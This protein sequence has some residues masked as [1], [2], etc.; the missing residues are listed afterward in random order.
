MSAAETPRGR[1]ILFAM[2]S[3]LVNGWAARD[4]GLSPRIRSV[5]ARTIWLNRVEKKGDREQTA[6][7]S[8]RIRLDVDLVAKSNVR[9]YFRVNPM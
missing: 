5:P 1:L 6:C 7:K 8:N 9:F 4:A 2:S 3:P